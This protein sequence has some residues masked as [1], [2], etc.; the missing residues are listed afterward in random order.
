MNEPIASE[1]D[2][3]GKGPLAQTPGEGPYERSLRILYMEDDAGMARLLQKHLSRAGY[4]VE[5]SCDGRLS[6]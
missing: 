3:T 5:V 6:R 1:P 2:I 4:R